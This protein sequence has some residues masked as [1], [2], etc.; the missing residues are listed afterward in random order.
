[1]ELKLTR[2]TVKVT[3]DE[4]TYDVMVPT[5]DQLEKFSD[6]MESKKPNAAKILRELLV[7]LG[8]P[9]EII[10]SMDIWS[11]NELVEFLSAK[12]K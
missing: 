4:K 2:K 5:T 10:R 8:L 3:Y 6:S 1:M 11:M 12:K 7:D 9:E